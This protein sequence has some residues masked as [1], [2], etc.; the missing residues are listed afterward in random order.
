MCAACEKRAYLNN[1]I[2]NRGGQLMPYEKCISQQWREAGGR[3]KVRALYILNGST[4]FIILSIYPALF[5]K[6][7][8]KE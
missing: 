8:F 4:A 6:P 5:F 3:G 1:A 2:N 7:E